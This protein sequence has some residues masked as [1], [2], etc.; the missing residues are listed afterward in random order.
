M[1]ISMMSQSSTISNFVG[2]LDDIQVL[3]NQLSPTV[4]E[5]FKN[6]FRETHQ[7]EKVQNANWLINGPRY[8]VFERR[9]SMITEEEVNLEITDGN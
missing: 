9:T 5:F 3:F 6:G 8:K 2:S 7:T 4:I 1:E